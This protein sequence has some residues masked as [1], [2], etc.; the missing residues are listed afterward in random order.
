VR[1][2]RLGDLAIQ[3][4]TLSSEL[5]PDEAPEASREGT[6]LQ[7][8]AFRQGE[9]TIVLRTADVIWVEAEDYYVRI[10]ASRGRQLVRTPL[11]ALEASLLPRS[12]VR[13]SGRIR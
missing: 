3:L 2:R 12:S 11:A 10:H 5:R 8:L 13:R 6:Y 1:E 9:R 7:R 4:A